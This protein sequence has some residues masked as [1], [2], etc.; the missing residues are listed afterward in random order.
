MVQAPRHV[1]P[2]LALAVV[3]HHLATLRAD[4]GPDL[5]KRAGPAGPGVVS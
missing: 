2:E 3:D 4:D 1:P 5:H